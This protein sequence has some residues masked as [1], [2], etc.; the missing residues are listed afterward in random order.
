MLRPRQAEQAAGSRTKATGL[1]CLS[2]AVL[3][4]WR[5]SGLQQ[6]MCSDSVVVNPLCRKRYIGNTVVHMGSA[7]SIHSPASVGC[8]IFV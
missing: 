4:E 5:P 2:G 3:G 6:L 8:M 7:F 1:W